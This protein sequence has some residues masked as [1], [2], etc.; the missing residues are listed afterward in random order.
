MRMGLQESIK[1]T[2]RRR[3]ED[4]RGWLLKILDGGEF[5]L[6]SHTGEVYVTMAR[7]GQARGGHYHRRAHEWFTVILGE[8]TVQLA[9]PASGE[10]L[11]L[12]LR[13]TDPT[14]LFVPAGMAHSFENTSQTNDDLL[15]AAYAS[16][17]YSPDD[18]IMFPFGRF[19][20][21]NPP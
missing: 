3:F 10:Y 4:E 20:D 18:T 19:R 16:E 9:D 13:G 12:Q 11:C 21:I 14:T 5:G 2:P 17:R 7:P 1:L 6:P 15:L 8:A